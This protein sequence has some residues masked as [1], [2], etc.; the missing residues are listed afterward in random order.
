M[1]WWVHVRRKIQNDSVKV[2]RRIVVWCMS[3]A[4]ET[5]QICKM[6]QRTITWNEWSMRGECLM[7]AKNNN[8]TVVNQERGNENEVEARDNEK[9]KLEIVGGRDVVR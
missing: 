9:E 3:E 7:S 2:R 6:F 8:E 4:Q 5:R 1:M